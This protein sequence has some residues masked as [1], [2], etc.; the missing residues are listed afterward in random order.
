MEPIGAIYIPDFLPLLSL[1]VAITAALIAAAS[2]RRRNHRPTTESS[3]PRAAAPAKIIYRDAPTVRVVDSQRVDRLR[4]VAR[5]APGEYVDVVETRTG[6]PPRFRITL[7]RIVACDESAVAHIAVEFG[8]TAVSCGPL[9]E[10]IGFN[11]FVLPRAA[12]DE[13]R[14]AVSHYQ[15]RG[16]A[17]DF[18]RIKL[19]GIDAAAGWADLDVMQVSGHWPAG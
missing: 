18:M 13:P 10:E 15:E 4:K 5:L 2:Y 6:L 17:L 19:R 7:K 8:G 3:M 9:V 14:N 12:R 1:T 16:D 11:E